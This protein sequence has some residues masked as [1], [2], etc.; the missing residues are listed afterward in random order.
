[1]TSAM[2]DIIVRLTNKSI[3][4]VFA[5]LIALSVGLHVAFSVPTTLNK[6]LGLMPNTNNQ[7]KA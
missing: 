6:K 7:I 5:A 2:A 4:L 3:P 1:M